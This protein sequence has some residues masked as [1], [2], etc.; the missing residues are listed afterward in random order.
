MQHTFRD[1]ILSLSEKTVIINT[2]SNILG[3]TE[4]SASLEYEQYDGSTFDPTTQITVEE[5]NREACNGAKGKYKYEEIVAAGGAIDKNDV[6]FL[7]PQSSLTVPQEKEDRILEDIY[8]D[9]CI[10]VTNLSTTVVRYNASSDWDLIRGGDI[11]KTNNEY[12]EIK[13]S[14]EATLTLL[15][16]YDGSSATN[17]DYKIFRRWRIHKV[18]QDILQIIWKFQARSL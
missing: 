4:I 7:I 1:E 10:N 5:W 6:F 12:Y 8:S 13:N 17:Q 18:E 3:D 2:V 9:G 11:L 14:Y 15:S 16:A